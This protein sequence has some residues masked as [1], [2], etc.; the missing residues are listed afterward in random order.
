MTHFKTWSL[1]VVTLAFSACGPA[2]EGAEREVGLSAAKDGPELRR[3]LA[4]AMRE[5]QGF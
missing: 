2:P 5:T 3:A 4:E 1:A